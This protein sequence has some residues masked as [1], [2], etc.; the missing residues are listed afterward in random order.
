MHSDE[1]VP[2]SIIFLNYLTKIPP[3][4]IF[5]SEQQTYGRRLRDSTLLNDKIDSVNEEDNNMNISIG[6]NLHI[7]PDSNR[8]LSDAHDTDSVPND[9]D[10]VSKMV[11]LYTVFADTASL[12]TLTLWAKSGVQLPLI[13]E[14]KE[15]WLGVINSPFKLRLRYPDK[16]L[17]DKTDNDSTTMN[18]GSHDPYMQI[19]LFTSSDMVDR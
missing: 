1:F 3:Y 7:L 17:V 18:G 4:H 12:E 11:K 16:Y 8:I 15:F 14:L 10:S 19:N 13:A 6:D 2:Y 9:K 5:S